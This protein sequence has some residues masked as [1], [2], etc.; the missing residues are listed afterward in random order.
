[1]ESFKLNY[2]NKTED[3]LIRLGIVVGIILGSI[4][5]IRVTFFNF[6]DN[7]EFGYKFDARTGEITPLEQKGYIISAPFIIKIHTIDTRPFQV[8]VSANNRVLNAKLVQFDPE[9]YELF[10]SWH[11]RDSYDQMELKPILMSYAF[12][13]SQNDYPFLKVLKELKNEDN[14]ST[15]TTATH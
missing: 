2:M 5:F 10:I 13:P 9:G 12:D 6:I 14:I 4:L 11:G 7:Y 8:S 15:D 3:I 1:M